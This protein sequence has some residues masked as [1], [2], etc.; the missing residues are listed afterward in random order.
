MYGEA[1]AFPFGDLVIR[2]MTVES[3]D[4][5]A[6]AEIDVPIVQ[7]PP[8]AAAGN[9]KVYMQIV[10][11]R[12]RRRATVTRGDVLVVRAGEQYSFHNGLLEMGRLFLN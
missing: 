7:N 8:Y 6:L 9:D 3:F 11:V 5:L 12:D 4:R 1:G 10:A 2:D